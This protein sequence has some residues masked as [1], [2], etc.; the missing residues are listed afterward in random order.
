MSEVCCVNYRPKSYNLSN[1]I[2][3]PNENNARISDHVWNVIYKLRPDFRN[4]QAKKKL[5]KY[6][7]TEAETSVYVQ[8]KIFL[9]MI[10]TKVSWLIRNMYNLKTT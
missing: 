5:K 10:T 6:L 3:Q 8:L 7:I 9:N 4:L 1:P 2:I